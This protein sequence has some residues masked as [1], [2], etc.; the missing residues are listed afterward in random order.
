ML[1][2]RLRS[3]D[4]FTRRALALTSNCW[5]VK[6]SV[7]EVLQRL[8]FS[9]GCKTNKRL[10]VISDSW[11]ESRGEWRNSLLIPILSH[12]AVCKH[13]IHTLEKCA[14]HNPDDHD[15]PPGPPTSLLLLLHSLLLFFPHISAAASAAVRIPPRGESTTSKKARFTRMT[16]FI[17][18]S[19]HTVD[20]SN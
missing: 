2:R 16:Q 9:S 11:S 8:A 7:Q 1:S 3:L 6:L 4:P 20:G 5:H 14:F 19:T 13:K 15:S 10:F 17:R 18:R 12:G